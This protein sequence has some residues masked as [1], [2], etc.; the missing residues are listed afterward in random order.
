MNI[1]LEEEECDKGFETNK[2]YDTS[3]NNVEE[4]WTVIASNDQ[5]SSVPSIQFDNV[6]KYFWNEYVDVCE[7]QQG[8]CVVIELIKYTNPSHIAF[9]ELCNKVSFDLGIEFVKSHNMISN[10]DGVCNDNYQSK[11]KLYQSLVFEKK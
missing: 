10:L 2:D 7:I 11:Q 5:N 6:K 3:N 8:R 9:A 4:L 1:G